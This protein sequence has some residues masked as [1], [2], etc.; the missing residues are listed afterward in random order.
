ML[1]SLIKLYEGGGIRT[2]GMGKEVHIKPI[3]HL[4]ISDT[5]GHNKWLGHYNSS[6][7]GVSRPY[8][9]CHCTF[10]DLLR[11][12]PACEYTKAIKFCRALRMMAKEGMEKMATRYFKLQSRH[13]IK[14]AMYQAR[15]PLSDGEYGANRM[16][17]PE[18]L[19]TL[20][21]GLTIYILESL[22]HLV[23]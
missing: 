18:L 22:G 6:K 1:K 3:I 7:P 16:R 17:P 19:H 12:N 8:R 13:Y 21:A 9:D 4:F 14:N 23:C 11:A 10:Y 15:L 2:V 5:D 20:D